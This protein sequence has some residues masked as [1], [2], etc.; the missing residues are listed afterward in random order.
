MRYC[1]LTQCVNAPVL[2][3]NDDYYE[4]LTPDAAVKLLKD[5]KAGK[6][7]KAGPLKRQNCEPHGGLTSLTEPPTGPGF[8]IRDDL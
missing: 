8:G 1:R 4:D 7:V 2:A 3:I 6:Q 5:I